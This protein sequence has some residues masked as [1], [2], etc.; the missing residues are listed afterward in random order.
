MTDFK[1]FCERYGLDPA[2]Q[3]AREQY[4][5][6][7]ANLRALYGAASKAE[8]DEAISKARNES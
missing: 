2:S 3:E 8:T 7:Q 4:D 6:A 5:Q 1:R